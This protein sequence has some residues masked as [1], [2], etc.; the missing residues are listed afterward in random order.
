MPN[1]GTV[2]RILPPMQK[3]ALKMQSDMTKLEREFEQPKQ[4]R[5]GRAWLEGDVTDY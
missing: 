3:D 2:M 4:D 5:T 1:S